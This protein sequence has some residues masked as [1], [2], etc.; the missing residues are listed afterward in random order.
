MTTFLLRLSLLPRLRRPC[1]PWRPLRLPLRPLRGG[2]PYS[3]GGS[4]GL[5]RMQYSHQCCNSSNGYMLR[6]G[7]LIKDVRKIFGIFDPFPLSAIW[8]DL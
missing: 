8:P 2:A 3:A 7:P 1:R 5:G 6:K 4:V